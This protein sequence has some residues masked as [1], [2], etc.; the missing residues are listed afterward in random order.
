M[1]EK[2]VIFGEENKTKRKVHLERGGFFYLFYF[3]AT[4]ESSP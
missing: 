1:V 3:N 4:G 2:N